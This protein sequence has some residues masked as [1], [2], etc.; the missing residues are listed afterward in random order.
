MRNSQPMLV[1]TTRRLKERLIGPDVYIL[2]AVSIA[3]VLVVADAFIRGVDGYGFDVGSSPVLGAIIG[4]LAGIFGEPFEVAVL[5]RGPLAFALAAAA[6]PLLIAQSIHTAHSWSHEQS[7]GAVEL[8]TLG[9]I[10]PTGY[11]LAMALAD[12]LV[13]AA[14]LVAVFATTL[15][16]GVVANLAVGP[17]VVRVLAASVA[18]AAV[19]LGLTALL[20]TLVKNTIGAIVVYLGVLSLAALLEIALNAVVSGPVPPLLGVSAGVVSVVSPVGWASRVLQAG[21]NMSG[22]LYF[23]VAVVTAGAYLALCHVVLYRRR[24]AR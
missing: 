2:P 22:L 5:A 13:A 10:S 14:Q 3:I 24:N 19:A 15:L 18:F 8:V 6:V 20:S 9:P 11:L 17:A 23:L 1:V 21:A 4:A 7:I 16:V 12:M